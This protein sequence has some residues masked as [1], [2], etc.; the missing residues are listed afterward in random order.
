MSHDSPA[1]NSS[2]PP[3]DAVGVALEEER[4]DTVPSVRGCHEAVS[5]RQ[6]D[7]PPTLPT[8]E[9]MDGKNTLQSFEAP[10]TPATLQDPPEMVTTNGS[11]RFTLPNGALITGKNTL[12]S[13]EAVGGLNHQRT[14]MDPP[15]ALAVDDVKPLSTDAPP[16]NPAAA[17]PS[18]TVVAVAVETDLVYAELAPEPVSSYV[19]VHPNGNPHGPVAPTTTPLYQSRS[20]VVWLTVTVLVLLAVVLGVSI[21]LSRNGSSSNEASAPI[22]VVPMD[23]PTM[24]PIAI[25]PNITIRAAVLTSYINNI[26]RSKQTIA[27]NGSS[28]ESQALAWLIYNDTLLETVAVISAEDPISRN[29]IGF[30]IQQR[31]ALLTMWFQQTDTAKWDNDAELLVNPNECYWFG[32]SCKPSYVYYDDGFN[33]GSQNTVTQISFNLI[34]SYVGVIPSDIG[35]LTTLEHFEIQ[36]TQDFNNANGRYLFGSLPDSIGQWTALTYFDISVN[37]LTGTLPDS[38]GQWTFLTYFD[39]SG[40]SLTGTLPDSIGQWTALTY[41][42]ISYNYALTGTLPN[43]IG[44]W[45]ALTSFVMSNNG[46]N[47]TLP[48]SI[49]QWTALTNFAAF[50]NALTGTLP[51]SIG[52]WTDLTSF[53]MVGNALTGT[54]PDS[55]GQ[56]TAL[57]IFGVISNGLTGTLPDSIGQWTALTFFVVSDNALNGTLPDS[58]G[59][60]TALTYFDVN[61]NALTGTLPENI[62]QWTALNDFGVSDNGLNGTLPDSIGQWTALTHFDISSNILNGTIPSSIGNWSLIETAFF[63]GNQ[64]VGIMPN[65]ICQYIDPNTDFLLVDC[66]VNCT[67]CTSDCL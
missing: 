39:V 67:C 7:P 36:N 9:V 59:Q 49:G 1:P 15:D 22:A 54:L 34:G 43:S 33:G 66:T 46:L 21:G 10:S 35:L 60:W 29:A 31:Y 42:D 48:D 6:S 25:D 65:A 50:E 45:T 4:A 12:Q 17:P 63:L 61:S 62:G 8:G 28:P 3:T 52:Q 19:P 24:A 2:D 41:F 5:F 11:V 14:P 57:I 16:P 32:I 64:L 44:Q 58:I 26:T 55:I 47:G 37:A 40:N 13:F 20:T 38:I 27:T 30:R 56:W 23:E 18:T 53:G 51:D